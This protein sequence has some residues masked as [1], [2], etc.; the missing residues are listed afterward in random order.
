VKATIDA[1]VSRL[2]KPQLRKVFTASPAENINICY[3]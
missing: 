2:A 1:T 3:A